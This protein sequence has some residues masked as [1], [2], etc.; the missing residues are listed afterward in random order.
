[1]RAIQKTGRRDS[2]KCASDL[3]ARRADSDVCLCN[4]QLD[5]AV[6]WHGNCGRLAKRVHTKT[7]SWS[8]TR[9]KR[10]SGA[11]RGSRDGLG[12]HKRQQ[13]RPDDGWEMAR[14][15]QLVN[16]SWSRRHSGGTATEHPGSLR[17]GKTGSTFFCRV[18]FAPWI[19]WDECLAHP[20]TQQ[21]P[22]LRCVRWNKYLWVCKFKKAAL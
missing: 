3:V 18:L 4:H 13:R 21:V 16:S 9:P 5:E 19:A 12:Q 22:K 17:R 20:F 15:P 1:M 14:A 7:K 10:E 2:A 11:R 8:A 6:Y